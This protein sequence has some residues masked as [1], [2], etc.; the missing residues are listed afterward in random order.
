[1]KFF[2]QN[3][4][5]FGIGQLVYDGDKECFITNLTRNSRF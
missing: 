5:E 4:D 3:I 1:M 2:A